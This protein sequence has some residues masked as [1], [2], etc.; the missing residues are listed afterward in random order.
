MEYI[1]LLV[2]PD[3]KSSRQSLGFTELE[4]ITKITSSQ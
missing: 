3:S 1:P 2:V 4:S